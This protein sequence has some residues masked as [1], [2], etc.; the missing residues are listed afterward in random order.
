[1]ASMTL[2]TSTRAAAE[3]AVLGRKRQAEQA[4]ISAS[5]AQTSRLQPSAEATILRRA[6]KS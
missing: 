3:A 5:V 6:S 1:M 2:I 4:Q